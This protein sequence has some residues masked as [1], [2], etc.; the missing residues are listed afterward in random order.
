M[1]LGIFTIFFFFGKL[2]IFTIR[3]IVPTLINSEYTHIRKWTEKVIF[4]QFFLSLRC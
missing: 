4:F 1:I 2:G 3:D